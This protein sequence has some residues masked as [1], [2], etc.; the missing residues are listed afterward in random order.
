MSQ[1][2]EQQE[3]QDL[4]ERISRVTAKAPMDLRNGSL[5]R[6]TIE[7]LKEIEKNRQL[8]LAKQGEKCNKIST[9]LDLTEK[10]PAIKIKLLYLIYLKN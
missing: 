10:L 6:K 1:L 7:S 9:V 4:G 3:Q 5:G 8:L 2:Q